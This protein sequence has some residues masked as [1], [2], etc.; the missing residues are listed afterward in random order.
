M[1]EVLD[2][3]FK[4]LATAFDVT[5]YIRGRLYVFVDFLM[6]NEYKNPDNEIP[7]VIAFLKLVVKLIATWLKIFPNYLQSVLQFIYYNYLVC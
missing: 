2:T 1:K 7:E 6:A 3:G 4:S 5:Q